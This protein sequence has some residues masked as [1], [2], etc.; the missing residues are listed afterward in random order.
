[1]RDSARGAARVR[2]EAPTRGAARVRLEAPTRGAARVRL[3]APRPEPWPEPRRSAE[4]DVAWA[5]VRANHGPIVAAI[6]NRLAALAPPAH[7]RLAWVPGGVA[8]AFAG[9]L[10]AALGGDQLFARLSELVHPTD[11]WYVID[12][13]REL[14]EGTPGRVVDGRAPR[15]PLAWDPLVGA[16]LA[17]E[18]AARVLESLA[19]MAPRY[20]AQLDEQHPAPVTV[21]D[22][23]TSHPMDRVTARLLCD[24]RVVRPVARGRGAAASSGAPRQPATPAPAPGLFRHGLRVLE[25]WRWLGDADARLWNWIEVKQPRDATAEDVAATLLSSSGEPASH[26]A[27]TITAAPPFF[28]FDPPWARKLLG[29]AAPPPAGIDR[30]HRDDA[31]ALADSA[32]ATEAAIAQAEGERTRDRHGVP[33]PP[34][35]ERLTAQ[36][37]RSARQLERAK[38]LLAPW[39]AWEP[40]LPAI[41]WVASH[42]EHLLAIPDHRLALLAPVIEGQQQLLFEAVGAVA[43]V[44]AAGARGAAADGEDGPIAGVLRRYAVAI[45]E[46]HL[47]GA[48]RA[49]LAAAHE[50]RAGLTLALME[51]S[52]RESRGAVGELQASEAGAWPCE[53]LAAASRHADYH[54]ELVEL[55]G[56]QAAGAAIDPGEVELLAAHLKAHTLEAKVKS[57]ALQLRELSR[58][59]GE[60][61]GLIFDAKAEYD[62]QADAALGPRLAEMAAELDARL[63]PAWAERRKTEAG[64]LGAARDRR[65]EARAV[66][67]AAAWAQAELD[68]FVRRHHLQRTIE[69]ALQSIEARRQTTAVCSAIAQIALLVGVSVVGNF[70]GGMAAGAVRGALLADAALATAGTLRA[71]RVAQVVGAA[72]GLATDAAVNTAAQVLTTG[73]GG[74]GSWLENFVSSGAV[75][76]ALRP[77]HAAAAAWGAATPSAEA[78]SLWARTGR[79]AKLALRAGAV[80]TAEMITG[81]AVSYLIH[82]AQGQPPDEKTA[83]TWALEGASMAIGKLVARRL[84][85]LEHRLVALAEHGVHLRARAAR[86]RRIAEQIERTGDKDQAMEVLAEHAR[87]LAEEA[88]LLERAGAPAG[89]RL[90][91]ESLATLRAGNRAERAAIEDQAFATMPLRLAGLEPDDG[92]GRVWIGATEDIAIALH[93]ASRSGLG[94]QVLGRDS[95][96]DAGA[97]QWRVLYN[98]EPLTILE[99]PL[100]GQPRP[101]RPHASGADRAHARRYAEAA[102][103]L[104]AQWEARTKADLD[105][106][107]VIELDHLQIGHSLAGVVNQATLPAAGE[108]L[109]QRLV[110]YD[111]KGTLTGRAGQELGQEPSKW[112]AAGVR[113]SEQAAPGAPWITSEEHRRSLDIGRLEVQTPAYRGAAIRLERR[114]QG[115]GPDGAEP[116]RA[117]S[118]AF[119]VLVRDAE[120]KARWFYA[121]RVDNAGG[122]GPADLQY[123]RRVVEPAQLDEMLARNQI[124]RGDDPDYAA[125]V[126]SGEIFVWGGTPTGAWGAEHAASAPGTKATIMGD[127]PRPAASWPRLLEEYEAV[128]R[129]IAAHSA[130]EVPAD[131]ARRKQQIEAQIQEAHRGMKLRRNRKPGAAYERGIRPGADAGVRIELGTPSRIAPAPDGRVLVTVG[132]GAD[133]RSTLYD[134]VVIAH[135]QDPGAPGAP[136]ALLGPGAAAVGAPGA[137]GAKRYGEVPT[138]TIAL[139]PIFGPRRDGA[140]PDLL[141]LESI[142]PPGL[143]LVGAAYATKKLSP[144]VAERE[145]A[146][147]E[148]AIDRMK[149]EGAPTRDHGPISDDST[150]VPAGVELQRDRIPRANEVLAARAYRLPG[151]EETLELDPASSARWDDQVRE[152]FAIHLRANGRWVKVQRLGGGYSRAIVYR[153][154]VDDA[155]VG[156]FKLFDGKDGAANEQAMLQRLEQAKLKK[157]TAVRERGRVSTD[158]RTGYEGGALLMDAAKGTSIKDLIEHLPSDPAARKPAFDQLTAAMKRAAEGLAEMHAKFETTSASGTPVMMSKAAKLKDANYFLDKSFRDGEDVAKVRAALGEADFRRVKAQ[159]EGPMLRAFLDTEVPATAYHGDANAGNFFV[160]DYNEVTGSYKELG[161]IDVGSM[162]WSVDKHTGKGIKTG[163]ADV[164]RLLG[165]LETLCP[166]QLTPAELQAL[167]SD[168][169]KTYSKQYRGEAR[170]DLDLAKYEQ[171]AKWYR[172]ELEVAVIKSDA[173]A[174]VR[175]QKILG[176]ET[177]P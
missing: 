125:K 141:G 100:R 79:G 143:R 97:R 73:H 168:F 127:T 122:M 89:A 145:R 166:G 171:A 63:L 38:A 157:M 158:A 163:A 151:P 112:D 98:G 13:H 148:R 62:G 3:E 153:V 114:P 117:P 131:L 24:E 50:A 19:R 135:G 129:E 177:S 159:L 174:K 29:P 76:L 71:A 161:L 173:R 96:G 14:V 21:A 43:E 124:L 2:L 132:T 108:G 162:V 87:L 53:G 48:A 156:V 57:L 69:S 160:N 30:P 75:L 39:G 146:A 81:A 1:M 82:R 169:M 44:A 176:L 59:A 65:A 83:M 11:P 152:W 121:D 34:D 15:G 133:A 101:A 20:A 16:A 70:A 95:V 4:P 46:S 93:Q 175:I 134:Q 64:A 86:A 105:A 111:H 6:G 8:A 142:D 84:Q 99:R 94:V 18:V 77:L 126:R 130:G 138:G 35:L 123:A 128:T 144:W 49:Q 12:Q 118:R 67:G 61:L 90:T 23:V 167:R 172:I 42:R 37:E 137:G 28:R 78:M 45:G 47:V 116:W 51:R 66:S 155:D 85:G 164:A 140:E 103:F 55:R 25:D 40:L 80:L 106:R 17:T 7:E 54:R 88:A 154:S 31:L 92:S 72:A 120:G 165:S 52:L 170:H 91:P 115:P 113:G 74:V 10:E 41:H 149:A 58:A 136:G 36:L 150:E 9:A 5:Y 22:L 60:G 32:L 109:G 33:L 104:Q 139:R 56:R 107:A 26:L 119:R 147:F 27:C 110:V 68:E 102:E